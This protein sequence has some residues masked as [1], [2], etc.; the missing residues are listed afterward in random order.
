[1]DYLPLSDNAARQVI[2]AATVF[3][4]HARVARD[5][6]TCAGGMYWKRQ[7]EYEYLVKTQPDNRQTR[8]G[9]RSAETEATYAAFTERK[10]QCQARLQSLR[11]AL[12]DAERMNKALKVGR[13]PALLITLLHTLAESGLDRH[14]TVVGT[15]ALYAYEM[16]AG[17][18]IVQ[19]A[20][21]TQ[22]VDLL[23]DAR[24]RVQF[25]ADMQ[26]LDVSMLQVL[27]RADPSFRRKEGQNETAINA[28]GFEVDFLRRQPEGDDP[29]PFRF[30]SD[31]EDLWPVQ[32][33]RASFLTSAARFEQ[34]VV[35]AT[36]RMAR[37]RTIAPA[38]FVAFKRWMA[39][40][41]PHRE[42]IKRRRDARQ[43]DIVQAL[44]DEGLLLN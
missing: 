11:M 20:L 32:A 26:R 1:M 13:A 23:W 4:E 14:F 9:A 10:A 31:E 24:R 18:R 33:R 6:R 27:Q 39:A 42:P 38:A 25:L 43:A 37:M 12:R 22:D 30:S 3:D 41:A 28:Q 35:S 40:E 5:A 44:L 34:V 8:I 7:G 15:H 36:G 2:D 19:G 16:A 29:H 21:A 17:V